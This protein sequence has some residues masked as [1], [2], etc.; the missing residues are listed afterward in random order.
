MNQT[1]VLHQWEASPFCRKVGRILDFKGLSYEVYNYN[2][3]RGVMALRL[4]KVGKLPVLDVQGLRVQDSTKI[5][6]LLDEL[7]PDKLIYPLDPLE[8]AKAELWEDWAD[9]VLYWFEGYFRIK[10]DIALSHFV[11]LMCEGRSNVEYILLKSMLKV[12]GEAGL[13][14]QG[15]GRMSRENVEAEF[16]RH[17]DRIELTLSSSNWLVGTNKTI[18]D[19][20]V[21]SQLHEFV[22]T[23]PLRREIEQRPHL[24]AWL[25]RI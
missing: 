20:A 13:K 21:G 2:G 4:S 24:N 23:S 14:M 9:E 15:I 22:R 17:L 16:W 18:A 3:L 19:I 25:K 5:A 8:R 11:K 10:D 6:R 12:A 1:I 7:Y